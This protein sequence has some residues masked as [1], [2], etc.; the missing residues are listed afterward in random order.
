MT[1]HTQSRVLV[2]NGP[3]ALPHSLY[4]VTFSGSAAVA[5]DAGSIAAAEAVLLKLVATG[6]MAAFIV[7][8]TFAPPIV[9]F[10]R[11]PQGHLLNLR[12]TKQIFKLYSG[13]II[14]ITDEFYTAHAAAK[15]FSSLT[16]RAIISPSTPPITAAV[17]R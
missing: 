4:I 11:K 17:C 7:K 14:N 1:L 16:G 10:C 8:M 12:N 13:K 3:R 6:G 9:G 15:L 2:A 5:P